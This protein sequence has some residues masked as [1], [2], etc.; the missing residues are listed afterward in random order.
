MTSDFTRLLTRFI[1]APHRLDAANA[2]QAALCVEDTVAVIY[3]GWHEP[4]VRRLA[5]LDGDE[6][7][8][9][10]GA[11]G[12]AGVERAAFLNAV[13]GHAL[14]FDDVH[15]LSVTH[16]SV[17]FVP[18]LLAM[19][20][21]RPET[22]PRVAPALAVGT[23]VNVALG[24]ILGFGHYDKGWHATSTIGAVAAAAAVAHQLDLGEEAIGNALSLAAALAGGLQINFGA[25]AKPIQAGNA[26]LVGLHAARMAE[27]GITGAPDIFA[28]RGFFDLYAGPDGLAADPAEVVP[29]IDLGSVS[30]KLY[31]CCYLTHRMIAAGRH[32]HAERGGDAVPEGCVI[33]MTVPKGVMV[34]LHVVDPKDG[35]E[36]KFC[37]AYTLS[38]ALHQG[39]VGL[40]DFEGNSPHRPEIRRLMDM[41]VIETEP[42]AGEDRV[43]VDH[44]AVHV[45]LRKGN[46]ILAETSV[47]AHPGSP[48]DPASPAEI[49][50]KIADCLEK[51]RRDGGAPPAAGAFRQDLRTRLHLPPLR[52]STAPDGQ[53]AHARHSKPEHGTSASGAAP[54][55]RTT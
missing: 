20:D 26:A 41:V 4:V 10:A 44:G 13:A 16:P 17:V 38:T 36:A 25:M 2:E 45:R 34:P 23:A 9:P 11:V 42:D 6:A 27:A 31:P 43:G 28:P 53:S 29:G 39:R 18:A 55:E 19:A 46:E 40:A 37:A 22:A 49:G 5:A 14:D 33:E 32:L 48:S 24:E 21:A 8:R 30:R 12:K 7:A 51:Y 1:V 52:H 35:M 50:Y 47:A 15:T 54:S 3:G